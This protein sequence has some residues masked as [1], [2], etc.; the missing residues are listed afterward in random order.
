[1]L[2]VAGFESM[3]PPFIVQ[4]YRD[5]NECFYKVY[6]INDEVMVFRRPS[7]PNLDDLAM[8]AGNERNP[9]H[10]GESGVACGLE[11]HYFGLKSVAF[12][13]RYA[14]PTAADF[15]DESYD[16]AE[17]QKEDSNSQTNTVINSYSATEDSNSNGS[18]NGAANDRRN[19]YINGTGSNGHSPAAAAGDAVDANTEFSPEKSGAPSSAIGACE[20]TNGHGAAKRP[21]AHKIGDIGHQK[22]GSS[23]SSTG[24]ST[25]QAH[26]FSPS[27]EPLNRVSVLSL[28]GR[29]KKPSA[30]DMPPL[31]ADSSP[32]S[33]SS[34][35]GCNLHLQ[36]QHQ[37]LD[38]A[39]NGHSNGTTGGSQHQNGNG[40]MNTTST[41]TSSTRA[42]HTAENIRSDCLMANA[43]TVRTT[44][45]A[46]KRSSNTH[47]SLGPTSRRK[48]ICINEGA[49]DVVL[50]H[51]S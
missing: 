44:Q 32:V 21:L 16:N 22:R 33:S 11:S 24:I 20:H 6:V 8:L 3:T 34:S 14:Y 17:Q 9:H 31:S 7:L 41:S 1:V 47:S 46:V 48:S 38:I 28:E 10:T 30:K 4:E 40:S 26:S 51:V 13:S 23:D 42:E 27:R 19:S 29:A 12:D 45:G 25:A 39:E 2:S 37:V 43:R 36:L 35:S 5:H 50:C 49:H 18:S 15:S